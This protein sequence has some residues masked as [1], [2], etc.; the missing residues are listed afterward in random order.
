MLLAGRDFESFA[1]VKD[2]VVMLYLE[3]EFSFQHKKELARVTV[4]VANLAGAGRH[5]LFDDAEL[6]RFDEVP[7]VA[8]G[9]LWASPF[10]VFGGF[11]ADDLSGQVSRTL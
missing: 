4:G 1:G 6:G 2:E 8:V 7:T 10:V 5:D 11:C 3:S 9:V